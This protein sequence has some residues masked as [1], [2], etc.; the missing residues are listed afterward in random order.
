[1]EKTPSGGVTQAK[2]KKKK[3]R[4]ILMEMILQIK[5]VF[6]VAKWGFFAG[7]VLPS[8]ENKP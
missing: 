7:N 3:K 2:E 6:L 1:M 5:N 8:R 4:L